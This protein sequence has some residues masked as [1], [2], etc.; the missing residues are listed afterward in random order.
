MVTKLGHD[1][2]TRFLN[3]LELFELQLRGPV[4]NPRLGLSRGAPRLVVVL[5]GVGGQEFLHVGVE[6]E[7]QVSEEFPRLVHRAE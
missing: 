3:L 2:A 7:A 1:G 4:G 6:V 5:G